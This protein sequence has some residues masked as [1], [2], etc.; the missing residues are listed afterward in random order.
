[1]E[2]GSETSASIPGSATGGRARWV[3][4]FT[5]AARPS[6]IRAAVAPRSAAVGNHRRLAASQQ[7]PAAAMSG[8]LTHHADAITKTAVRGPQ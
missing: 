6:A 1:M 7:P 4:S 5:S 8:H 3:T 2:S